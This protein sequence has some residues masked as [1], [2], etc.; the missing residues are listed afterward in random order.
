MCNRDPRN[1]F[2]DFR[3]GEPQVPDYGTLSP[4]GLVKPSNFDGW[5]MSA[6]TSRWHFGR[7]RGTSMYDFSGEPWG[8]WPLVV[9]LKIRSY[10]ITSDVNRGSHGSRR[11]RRRYARN[12]VNAWK[13]SDMPSDCCL[14]PHSAGWFIAETQPWLPK[15]HLY[16]HLFVAIALLHSLIPTHIYK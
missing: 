10:S 14:K 5:P 11:G 12:L 4:F 1:L 13:Q 16:A 9:N 15:G 8:L 6:T 2:L 7:L 3:G